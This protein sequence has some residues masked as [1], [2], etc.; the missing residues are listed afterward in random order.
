[1]NISEKYKGIQANIEWMSHVWPTTK[2]IEGRITA[3][4]F[5]IAEWYELTFRPPKCNRQ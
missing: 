5:T 2:I 1:M 4:P 3:K